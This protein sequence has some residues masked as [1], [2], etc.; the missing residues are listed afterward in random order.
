MTKLDLYNSASDFARK[1]LDVTGDF[2]LAQKSVDQF[3][4]EKHA[5]ED[6]PFWTEQFRNQRDRMLSLRDKPAPSTAGKKPKK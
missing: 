3:K 1:T 2:E 4:A 5:P 6:F